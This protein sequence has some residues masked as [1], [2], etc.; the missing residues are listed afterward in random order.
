MQRALKVWLF[1]GLFMVFIQI[2]IGG[3]T[4]LT[5]SGLS[6]TKWEIVTG[7][8]PPMSEKAWMK[9]F[10]LYKDTPQY[11]KINEGMSLNSFKFI[12]FWEYFHRLW[13]R[14]IGIVFIIPFFIFYFRKTLS[15][16]LLSKLLK[17]V[18]LGAI[19][20]MFGW[21]MV[22][23]GLVDRPWVNAYKLSFH[24]ILAT[25][26]FWY[27]AKINFYV[28]NL[29]PIITHYR[30]KK[31]TSI[32]FFLVFVQIFFGGLMAG[33]KA[34]I[35][36]PT[37]PSMSGEYFPKILLSLSEYS[38]ANI[39]NYDQSMFAPTLVHFLHRNSGYLIL[40]TYL[41]LLWSTIKYSTKTKLK[42]WILILG[43]ILLGQIVLGVLT[44][45]NSIGFVPLSYGIVHQ[46]IA[47]ILF[48][49]I[50]YIKD[51]MKVE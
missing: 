5:G 21:I 39:E 25:I 38:I 41:M 11:Q 7:S 24:L 31:L 37:W 32:L 27:L 10:E 4:R 42:N 45:L 16:R 33:M 28:W 51:R 13:A 12:Y 43:V 2:I 17:L 26:V 44:L 49:W 30:I 48:F 23:S 47:F 18:G 20:G 22:A 29:S 34:A 3:I 50:L 19:V 14:S 15:K 40:V 46:G 9:E 35:L 36:I 1:I 6:I 8:I